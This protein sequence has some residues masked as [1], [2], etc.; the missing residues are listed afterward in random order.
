MVATPL[1]FTP[2]S[3]NATAA[4]ATGSSHDSTTQGS[5]ASTLGQRL[6]MGMG[7]PMTAG[8]EQNR[9]GGN[10]GG[11]VGDPTLMSAAG[12]DGGQFL[13]NMLGLAG[14][15]G[16]S[17]GAGGGTLG[18]LLTSSP[19]QHPQALWNAIEGR[20]TRGQSRPATAATGGGARGAVDTDESEGGG[21]AD[22]E[23]GQ[24]DLE[25]VRQG[26]LTL[27]TLLSTTRRRSRR[28]AGRARAAGG[29]S[30]VV[31]GTTTDGAT[32]SYLSRS[33]SPSAARRRRR[34]PHG[35]TMSVR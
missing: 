10:A 3:G 29:A 28:G 20:A 17:A 7:V 34:W 25:H 23:D 6:L 14:A 11:N 1:G 15:G 27:H 5:R 24:T 31:A 21:R 2:P 19:T 33:L 8:G 16:A 18:D 13:T 9:S 26:L 32:A 22:G 35:L 12:L 30:A 4:T